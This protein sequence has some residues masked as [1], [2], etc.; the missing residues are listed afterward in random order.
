[1]IIQRLSVNLHTSLEERTANSNSQIMHLQQK[2][3][4]ANRLREKAEQERNLTTVEMEAKNVS[5]LSKE[6]DRFRDVKTQ[7]QKEYEQQIKTI[8]ET[9]DIEVTTPS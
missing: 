5:E 8:R 7:M 2:L 4:E 9:Y 1:M 3:D 6:K